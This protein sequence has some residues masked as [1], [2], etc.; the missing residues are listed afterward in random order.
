MSLTSRHLNPAR[1]AWRTLLAIVCV[2]FTSAGVNATTLESSLR[3]G[4]SAPDTFEIRDVLLPLSAPDIPDLGVTLRLQRF[5]V[6]HPNARFLANGDDGVWR[7]IPFDA[8]S[9]QF[10]RGTVDG[11]PGSRALFV[12]ERDRV[13]GTVSLGPGR[14]EYI[15]GD[16]NRFVRPD[17]RARLR[18]ASHRVG[19]GTSDVPPCGTPDGAAINDGSASPRGQRRLIDPIRQVRLAIDSDDELRQLFGSTEETIIYLVTLHAIVADMLLR[20]VDATFSITLVRIWETEDPYGTGDP[21]SVLGARWAPGLMRDVPRDIVHLVSGRRDLPASGRAS[22]IGTIANCGGYAWSGYMQGIVAPGPSILARDALLAAHEIGHLLGGRHTHSLGIDDCPGDAPPQRGTVMSY[23]GLTF[24]GESSV[25]DPR[26]HRRVAAD[27]RESLSAG[28]LET[29]CDLNGVPDSVDIALGFLE[30]VDDNGIADA[31][32]DCDNDGVPDPQSIALDPSLDLNGNGRLDR[33]ELDC[34]NDGVPDELNNTVDVNG[35]SLPDACEPDENNNGISDLIE[36][37][38]EMS[39]DLNRNAILD[40]TEDC[41][42]DGVPDLDQLA[43]SGAI[44]IAD[45]GAAHLTRCLGIVGVPDQLSVG[46][47]LADPRDVTITRDGNVLV[48][49]A[50]DSVI[51]FGPDGAYRRHLAGP[52]APEI[53]D[54]RGL[55]VLDDGSVAVVSAGRNAVARLD[56][57]TGE[58]LSDLIPPSADGPVGPDGI[59]IDPLGRIFL[60]SSDDRLFRYDAE[61]ASPVVLVDTVRAGLATM[62]DPRGLVILPRGGLVVASHG[63]D[64]LLEFDPDDGTFRGRFDQVG[65]LEID[66]P[67]RLRILAPDGLLVS[68]TNT[69]NAETGLAAQL[70]RPRILQLDAK[71]GLLVRSLVQGRDSGILNPTG[72]A[73]LPRGRIDCNGNLIP[74]ACEIRTAAS[75]DL[76]ANGTP[77]ECE[78]RACLVDLNDDGLIGIEDLLLY[79]E[80]WLVEEPEADVTGDVVITILDLLR[81][82]QAW[83]TGTSFGLCE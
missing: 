78:P 73:V 71:S 68:R 34:D 67:S 43:G 10:L 28:C 79:L 38:A 83:L 30:D 24:T 29:D 64:R 1:P 45:A 41:D 3:S 36:I 69:D 17:Q 11:Y 74:D 75:D 18:A 76:N 9:I 26:F 50:T 56:P 47:E 70:R 32:E 72:F 58:R 51:E 55:H 44:W 27:I 60:T 39:L 59:T 19:P 48:S 21:I 13:S 80:V 40:A 66:G 65:T 63:T 42:R 49:D 37:N 77:D 31:C 53:A 15:I 52:D 25:L 22:G 7:Q 57:T 46:V 8:E 6:V 16:H 20:D 2:G 4:A 35:N 62:S 23:C 61:G 12:L 54:P 14:A 5:K 33:C 82:L 81:F